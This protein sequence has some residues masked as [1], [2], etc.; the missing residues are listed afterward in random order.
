MQVVVVVVVVAVVVVV[1]M[2]M[3]ICTVT[4]PASFLFPEAQLVI[5]YTTRVASMHS[6][7]T[8]FLSL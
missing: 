1:D 3:S 4:D 5:C 8:L 6:N 2:F 7:A